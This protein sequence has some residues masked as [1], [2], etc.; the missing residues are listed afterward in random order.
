M[1]ATNNVERITPSKVYKTYAKSA[2]L[3]GNVDL[4]ADGDGLCRSIYCAEAG[5]LVV[6]KPDGTNETIPFVAGMLLPIVAKGLV[7]SGSTVK[8]IVVLW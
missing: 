6:T 2:A 5:D 3:S 7:A 4:V 1:I 8:G